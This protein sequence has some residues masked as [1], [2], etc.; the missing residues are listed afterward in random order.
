[1]RLEWAGHERKGGGG[2]GGGVK[3]STLQLVMKDSGSVFFYH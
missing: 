2:W 1:M 3:K